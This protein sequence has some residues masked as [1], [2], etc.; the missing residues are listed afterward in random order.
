MPFDS[1]RKAEGE[2]TISGD[3]FIK[4]PVQP[5]IQTGEEKTIERELL[6][7]YASLGPRADTLKPLVLFYSRVGQPRE[8]YEYLRLWF[9]KTKV[10]EEKAEILLMCGQIAEQVERISEAIDFYREGIKLK[11]KQPS[12]QYFLHNNVAY[13]LNQKAEYTEAMEHCQMAFEIDST[14]SHAYKNMGLAMMG[15]GRYAEAAATWIKAL[16][17]D[18][19]DRRSLDLLESLLSSQSEVIKSEIPDIQQQVLACRRAVDS[20]GQGRFS[21]WAKGLTFN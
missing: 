20:A 15:L 13:C 16:H 8:A 9:S 7:R 2:F 4:L 14:R 18:A 19:S 11:P 3:F 1:Q 12:V 17:V 5:M 6:A 21:D 10:R